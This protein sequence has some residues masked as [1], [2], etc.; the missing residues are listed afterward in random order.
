[1]RLPTRRAGTKITS[2]YHL[3]SEKRKK[4]FHRIPDV[5]I[6]TPQHPAV[7]LE[8]AST[9]GRGLL[10]SHFNKALEY[11]DYLILNW[12]CPSGINSDDI[13]KELWEACWINSK[14]FD[15]YVNKLK[16]K[17]NDTLALMS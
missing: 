6:E 8:L 14:T 15:Q 7:A 17:S 16:N 5:V 1:M 11:K 9:L 3:V 12:T 10:E 2:Q 4:K 13:G